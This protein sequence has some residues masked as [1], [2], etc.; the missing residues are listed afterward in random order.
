M[1]QSNRQSG[2]TLIELLV[3]VAIIGILAAIA[4]PQYSSYKIRSFNAAA[5]SDL[6][7]AITA[8]EAVFLDREAYGNCTDA[9]CNDPVLPGFRLS[10]GV[11]ITCI[12]RAAGTLYQCSTVH[13]RG[14]TTYGFDSE[15][16]VF[17]QTP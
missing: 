17:S 10:N 8:Q 15:T 1:T 6:K 2:F 14:N 12:P 9:G 7:S 4:M 3:V 5:S 11:S 13:S 16:Y